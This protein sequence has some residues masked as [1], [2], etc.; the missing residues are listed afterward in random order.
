MERIL[1][2]IC[3]C[4]VA[5]AMVAADNATVPEA[6]L[7]ETLHGPVLGKVPT[8]ME[9]ALEIL[10]GSDASHFRKLAGENRE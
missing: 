2:F 4:G 10:P 9:D 1:L 7:R 5:L 3:Y 6:S 8:K